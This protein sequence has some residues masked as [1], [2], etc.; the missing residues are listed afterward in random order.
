MTIFIP[1]QAREWVKCQKILQQ[2]GNMRLDIIH[3]TDKEKLQDR[4]TFLWFKWIN[5]Y[6]QCTVQFAIFH[7]DLFRILYLWNWYERLCQSVVNIQ[8][9]SNIFT[10][11]LI[12]EYEYKKLGYK[13]IRIFGSIK[14]EGTNIFESEQIRF[15][16]KT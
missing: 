6:L 7:S 10:E 15:L 12:F 14:C 4:T 13:Y 16:W 5:R 11:Y 1:R 3:N 9:Y 8:I 2:T